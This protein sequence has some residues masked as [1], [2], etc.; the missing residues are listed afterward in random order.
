M[1][2]IH[3]DAWQRFEE[4]WH[5]DPHTA[6]QSPPATRPTVFTRQAG[7]RPSGGDWVQRQIALPQRE[8]E[9]DR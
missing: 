2:S 3:W 9:R 4:T 7:G 1:P 6:S 8:R 5:T